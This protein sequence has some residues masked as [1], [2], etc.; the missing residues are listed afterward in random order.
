MYGVVCFFRDQNNRPCKLMLG[1]PEVSRHAGTVIAHKVRDILKQ[2]KIE[3]KIGYAV[4][5]NATNS[6][7]AMAELG[8]ELGFSGPQ[9]CGRGIGHTINLSA[10]ALL[11]GDHANAFEEQLIGDAPL[12]KPEYVLCREKGPVIKFHNLII[13]VNR[14]NSYVSS[15]KFCCIY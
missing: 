10:K 9:R 7:T 12:I 1:P 13:E 4:F 11:F 6:D 3:N 8:R 15:Y 5:D 2:F 14:S